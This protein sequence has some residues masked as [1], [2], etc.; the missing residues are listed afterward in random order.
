[1]NVL[2]ETA[3]GGGSGEAAGH[4]NLDALGA[5]TNYEYD[6]D[7]DDSNYAWVNSN[8]MPVPASAETNSDGERARSKSAIKVPLH[9][10]EQVQYLSVQNQ[11]CLK[12]KFSRGNESEWTD[13]GAAS[14][15]ADQFSFKIYSI[16]SRNF[17]SAYYLLEELIEQLDVSTK[18][19]LALLDEL[20][21]S[22]IK[23]CCAQ[24]FTKRLKILNLLVRIIKKVMDNEAN[25]DTRACLNFS[26][27]K[28]L[29]NLHYAL[30]RTGREDRN[31]SRAL[32]ELFFFAEKLAIQWSKQVEYTAHMKVR[33]E[34]AEKITEA[35]CFINFLIGAYNLNG[36]NAASST[37]EVRPQK[38]QN[39]KGK[40]TKKPAAAKRVRVENQAEDDQDFDTEIDTESNAENQLNA[41]D[42]NGTDNEEKDFNDNE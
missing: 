41:E 3:T 1:M 32:Y 18:G 7:I 20:W 36:S 13:S 2:D 23:I 6:Y 33:E 14:T 31:L 42:E 21:L 22:L 37:N 16:F 26:A 28:P 8:A 15:T 12:W 4:F 25:G 9:F 19:P 30:E 34:F 10:A 35:S 17:D 38:V 5:G 39:T 29:K 27:L 24:S 40:A 11:K